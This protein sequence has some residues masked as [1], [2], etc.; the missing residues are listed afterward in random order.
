MSKF[1]YN[2]LPN[3]LTMAPESAGTKTLTAQCYCKAVSYTVTLPISAFPLAVHLCHCSVCRYTHG[4]MCI[5]HAPLPKDVLIQFVAPSSMDNLT[6]YTHANAK[7]ERFFCST[8]GCHIGDSSIQEANKGQWVIA[9]SL[10]LEQG[11]HVFQ[12]KAHCLTKCAPGGGLYDWL[13]RIADREMTIWNPKDDDPDWD[14][15]VVES[16]QEFG[17]DGN[18]RLRAQCHCGGVSFTIPRPNIPAVKDD[19]SLKNWVSPVDPTKW[20]ACLDVCDDCRL[21]DGTHVVG[22]T[23][24]PRALLD[25]PMP[26]ALSGYGTLKPYVSS[27]GVIR[28]F[29]GRCGAT[30]VY[31]CDEEGD[32]TVDIATG[33]LRAPEGVAAEKW[34]TWRTGRL[35]W[36]ESGMRYDPVFTKALA[37]GFRKWGEKKFGEALSFAIGT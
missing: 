1:S 25:P 27:K 9:T 6:G 24:V 21:V 30:V 22:W 8:C 14:M 23:F 11:E 18:E 13:P 4:T 5:F 33:I 10:F 16:K 36:Y 20:M 34:L 17:A 29:C 26:R 15:S 19:P 12:I 32:A 2:T 3:S 7:S 28:G 37:E 35:S 31:S